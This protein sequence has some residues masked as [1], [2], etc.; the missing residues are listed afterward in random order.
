MRLSIMNNCCKIIEAPPISNEC[1]KNQSKKLQYNTIKIQIETIYFLFFGILYD[2]NDVALTTV[3]CR[4]H[5]S[6]INWIDW[7]V[8]RYLLVE[9]SIP[10]FWPA[11]GNFAIKLIIKIQ[12]V[13][14]LIINLMKFSAPSL[15][16][17][18][19]F[20]AIISISNLFFG[21]HHNE[22]SIVV[23]WLLLILPVR[24]SIALWNRFSFN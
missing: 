15:S 20:L 21:M 2:S 14:P 8:G 22:N 9:R 6:V 19:I 7:L 4:N 10:T 16:F 17:Y 1:K 24:C 13:K 5:S 23:H 11:Y 18:L 3:N 12:F